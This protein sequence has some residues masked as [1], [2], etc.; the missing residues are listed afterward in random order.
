MKIWIDADA[1]PGPVKE[2]V[3]RAS[4]RL[5]IAV[6]LVANR[7][8]FSGASPLITAVSVEQ[9]L[10][11]ADHYLVQHAERGD[12]VITADIPL[13]AR[14]VAG[15]MAVLNP[16]G[17]AYT[18]EN[19]RERLSLR[20]FKEALRAAGAVTGGPAPYH[21]RDKRAFANALDRWLAKQQPH[22]P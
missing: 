13:A 15:G 2:M 16:R 3:F 14:L 1:C 7:Q 17:E 18:V 21:D 22:L 12:L 19:I 11:A 10:D 20:D 4:R 6:T 5:G 9:T 8:L